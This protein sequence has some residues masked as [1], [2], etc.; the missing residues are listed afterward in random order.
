MDPVIQTDLKQHATRCLITPVALLPLHC[1][2]AKPTTD[3]KPPLCRHGFCGGGGRGT[4]VQKLP[5]CGGIMFVGG[6]GEGGGG[7]GTLAHSNSFH[8]GA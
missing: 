8:L 1:I 4:T 5:W 2:K 6:R 3:L 7:E